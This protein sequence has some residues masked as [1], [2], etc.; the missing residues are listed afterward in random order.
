MVN[1][2]PIQRRETC[3]LRQGVVLRATRVSRDFRIDAY[4][5]AGSP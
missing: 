3:S 2:S 1:S 4:A 5:V